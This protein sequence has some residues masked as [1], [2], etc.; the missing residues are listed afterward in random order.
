M[1]IKLD[2]FAFD[3]GQEQASCHDA[4]SFSPELHLIKPRYPSML[5]LASPIVTTDTDEVVIIGGRFTV[6]F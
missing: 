1:S 4:I 6:S 5:D 2:S 3:D